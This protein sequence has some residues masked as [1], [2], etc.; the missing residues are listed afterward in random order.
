MENPELYKH[1]GEQLK[2][3][4]ILNAVTIESLAK[5]LNRSRDFVLDAERARY[6][7]PLDKLYEYCEALDVDLK[8]II[9][10]FMKTSIKQSMIDIERKEKETYVFG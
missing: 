1:I 8:D 2:Y 5:K 7:I 4:R 3:H 6:R 9:P 10:D